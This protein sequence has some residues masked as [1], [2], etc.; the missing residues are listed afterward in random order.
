MKNVENDDS[1]ELKLNKQI[2]SNNIMKEQEEK[3]DLFQIP[4]LPKGKVLT[5]KILTNWG[6]EN[7]VGFNGIEIFD[8]KTFQLASI[9]KVFLVFKY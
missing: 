4:W 3:I 7:Y 1:F 8:G 2:S 6:D 5:M 9:E